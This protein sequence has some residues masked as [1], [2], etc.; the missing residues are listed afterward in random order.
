MVMSKNIS[1]KE[2][3]WGTKQK[4]GGKWTQEGESRGQSIS[5]APAVVIN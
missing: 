3:F 1:R 5:A 4:R 2:W